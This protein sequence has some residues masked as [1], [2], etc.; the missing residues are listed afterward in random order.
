MGLFSL[1]LPFFLWIN[2]FDFPL[3]FAQGVLLGWIKVNSGGW[4]TSLWIKRVF[5][6]C[7]ELW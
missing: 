4:T 1:S 6:V 3:N 7:G 2:D 5:G